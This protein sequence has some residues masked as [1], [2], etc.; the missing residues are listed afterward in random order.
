MYHQT[1]PN[2]P[3][4]ILSQSHL[5]LLILKL[6]A[7]S[8]PEDFLGGTGREICLFIL[9]PIQERNHILARIVHIK[10]FREE[11]CKDIYLPDITCIKT[12]LI[13]KF[14]YF[15]CIHL[16]FVNC[17]MIF[18][19]LVLLLLSSFQ[20]KLMGAYGSKSICL[21]VATSREKV[22]VSCTPPWFCTSLPGGGG[23]S[24]ERVYDKIFKSE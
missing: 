20:N 13:R 5:F 16:P 14:L 19:Y 23:D 18:I 4:E 12:I 22:V 24:R 2:F 21:I 11:I 1:S 17:T 3:L 15:V 9:K 7:N 10:L 8:V 6:V